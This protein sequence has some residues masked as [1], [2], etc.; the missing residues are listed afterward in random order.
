M[1]VFTVMV[2]CI[3]DCDFAYYPPLGVAHNE[4]IT[5][6]RDLSVLLN[7]NITIRHALACLMGLLIASLKRRSKERTGHLGRWSRYGP[8]KGYGRIREKPAHPG[9]TQL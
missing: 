6:Q 4:D 1:M 2:R 3:L 8:C 5:E 9:P 7:I